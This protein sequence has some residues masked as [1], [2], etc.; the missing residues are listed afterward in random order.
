MGRMNDFPGEKMVENSDC[1]GKA[2]SGG[3]GAGGAEFQKLQDELTGALI[4]LAH[5]TDGGPEV[6]ERTWQLLIDGLL[7]SSGSADSDAETIGRQIGKT[8]Q[9]SRAV[10]PDCAYCADPCGRYADYDMSRLW[11]ADEET[12]SAK[13][14]ILEELRKMASHAQRARL[15]GLK[16]PEVDR[17]FGEGLFLI[18]EDMTAEELLPVV[19]KAIMMNRRC[20][21]LFGDR[22]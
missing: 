19:D 7:M 21:E 9:Q 1:T 11:N 22:K 10:R 5:T 14:K 12:R 3:R 13:R 15:R 20:E 17:F 18:G 16:D 6:P 4:G 2:D 8:H